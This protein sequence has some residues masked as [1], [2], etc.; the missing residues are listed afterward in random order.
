[1]VNIR[2]ILAENI[3]KN[4]SLRGYSQDKMAELAGIS[5]QY[6]ATIE[7]CRK[8]PTPEV[9]ECIAHALEI[10]TYELF[11]YSTKPEK[12]LNKLRQEI[13]SEVVNT[14]RQCFQ[15]DKTKTAL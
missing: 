12:E 9:M 13:I 7:T 2:E 3:K 11:S 1:M 14:I 8:F 4:R 15:E 5:S 6:L 10:E